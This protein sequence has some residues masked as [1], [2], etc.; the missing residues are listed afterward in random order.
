MDKFEAEMIGMVNEIKF[1]KMSNNIQQKM[2]EDMRRFKESESIFVKSDKSG[3]LY[4]IEKGKLYLMFIY[5]N[6][7]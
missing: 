7:I 2:Y 1:R 4:E 6:Y 3:N 5:L